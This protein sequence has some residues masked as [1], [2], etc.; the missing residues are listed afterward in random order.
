MKYLA[1]ASIRYQ[2]C[3]EVS[4]EIFDSKKLA[5]KYLSAIIHTE[6]HVTVSLYEIGNEIPLK[7][8]K[9]EIAQPPITTRKV[10]LG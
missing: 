5:L 1:V 8:E 3:T 9:T 6:S 4:M 10:V 7:V 2:D